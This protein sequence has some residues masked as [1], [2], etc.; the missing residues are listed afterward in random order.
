MEA[1][2]SIK[3]AEKKS[4][5]MLREAMIEGKEIVKNAKINANNKYKCIL[6][7]AAVY[8]KEIF[9]SYVQEGNKEADAIKESG[10]NS[11][12]ELRNIPEEKFNK[13][14]NLVIERIV[15]NNGNS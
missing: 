15:S 1:I 13:A 12:S 3:E 10:K 7:E 14:V 11:I 8:S 5:N 9:D 6:E 2:K 4:E